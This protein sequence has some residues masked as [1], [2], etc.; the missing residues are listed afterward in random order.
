MKLLRKRQRVQVANMNH[1]GRPGK[2]GSYEQHCA[3][4]RRCGTHSYD[5]RSRRTQPPERACR[6]SEHAGHL[7]AGSG[8]VHNR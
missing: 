8:A 7:L 5:S 1:P 2:P 6:V 3:R 4:E